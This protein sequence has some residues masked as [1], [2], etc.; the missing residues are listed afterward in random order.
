MNSINMSKRFSHILFR[1]QRTQFFARSYS[2]NNC[3]LKKFLTLNSANRLLQLNKISRQINLFVEQNP[4]YH[5]DYNLM[6]QYMELYNIQL[7]FKVN[8]GNTT[9]N[10]IE[11]KFF[12]PNRI[13]SRVL[14]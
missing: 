4:N 14:K 3:I 13:Y 11:W 7:L 2:Q 6:K 8:M 10:L 5:D 9:L 1:Q 12:D